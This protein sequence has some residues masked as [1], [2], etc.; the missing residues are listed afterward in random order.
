MRLRTALTKSKN[1]VSIRVMDQIGVRYA[2]DYIT[3]FGFSRKEHPA[4]LTMALGAGSATVWGM[5]NG[6]AV[7]ANGGFRVKPHLIA[8]ITD[9]QGNIIEEAKYPRANQDAPRVIDKRNAFLMTSMMH[10]VVQR[11]TATKARQLG[12]NDL[13]GKTGTTNNQVDAW[14]AG[15]NPKQVAVAWIGYDQPRSL[16]RDET[17]GKAALPIWISYMATAL[18]GVPDKPFVVPDGVMTVKID[19][20]TG[21]LADQDDD[22]AINEYFYHENPPPTADTLLPPMLE[23]AEP[24]FS[25]SLIQNPLQA[26][27]PQ[28][29]QEPQTLPNS[30]LKAP[31][32]Q[33][34][35]V[36]AGNTGTA[37]AP[38]RATNPPNNSGPKPPP[39]P[40][41]KTRNST[42][43]ASHILNPSGY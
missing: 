6:Y 27:P 5:A 2:Q 15:Y 41:N 3:K 18:K 10:D 12:R 9:S 4:Y 39:K 29:P 33:P 23:P 20:V 42:D 30:Q 35:N 36:S 19:P 8:K 43:S 1:M 37:V 24:Y 34:N 21:V 25:D 16:G 7:F 40:T 22:E 31:G 17:G 11:G 26:Q 32:N 14:F 38:N 28:L 13:A